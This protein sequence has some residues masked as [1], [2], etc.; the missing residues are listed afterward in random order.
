MRPVGGGACA[1]HTTF[2]HIFHKVSHHLTHLSQSLTTPTPSNTL[3]HI[4]HTLL[5]K[6]SQF[7]HNSHHRSLRSRR[8]L[9]RSYNLPHK[10]LTKG[11]HSPHKGLTKYLHSPHIV[12]TKHHPYSHKGHA[13]PQRPAGP[14]VPPTRFLKMVLPPKP[15]DPLQTSAWT[16]PSKVTRARMRPYGPL[17]RYFLISPRCVLRFFGQIECTSKII[18]RDPADHS[19]PSPPF[20]FFT[21]VS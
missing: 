14:R 10:G 2:P 5:T 6:S 17:L 20:F 16:Y 1:A 8:R 12:P 7:P 13:W 18:S 15:P 9:R 21:F 11:S 19:P 3:S 4:F